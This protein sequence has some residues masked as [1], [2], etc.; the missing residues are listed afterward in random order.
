MST[1]SGG[2]LDGKVAVIT[3]AASGIGA[4]TARMFV[5]EGAKVV[6]ADLQDDAGQA[7][8]DYW[9]MPERQG[10]STPH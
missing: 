2:R 1:G 4:G 9:A 3:G 7:D 6:V 5:A 10:A 8:P